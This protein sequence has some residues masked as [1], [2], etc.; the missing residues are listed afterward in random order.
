MVKKLLDAGKT[1]QQVIETLYIRCLTRKPTAEE[2]GSVAG[3][4]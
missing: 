1:P 2:T 3:R 4:S